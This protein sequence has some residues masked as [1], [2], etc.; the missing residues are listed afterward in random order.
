MSP[1]SADASPAV[2]VIVSRQRLFADALAHDLERH[3]AWDLQTMPFEHE[4]LLPALERLSPSVVVLVFDETDTRLPDTRSLINAAPSTRFVAVAPPTAP[5]HLPA[6][7][8]WLPADASLKDVRYAVRQAVAG[9]PPWPRSAVA[10]PRRASTELSGTPL[11]QRETDVLAG[12]ASGKST[13]AMAADLGISQATVRK[14][15]QH[16]LQK[17]DVHSKLEAAA[18][19]KRLGIQ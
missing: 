1:D 7:I 8:D 17:L 10:G 14:H 11:S 19:A 16:I 6:G 18:V 13:R 9:K 12:F 5:R 2:V 15:V 4:R 3:G